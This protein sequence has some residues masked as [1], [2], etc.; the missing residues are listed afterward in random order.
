[1]TRFAYVE[2]G[3]FFNYLGEKYLRCVSIHD[4]DDD[5]INAI[6]VRDGAPCFF[7]NEDLV[8]VVEE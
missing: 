3:D 6:R 4:Q 8:E 2:H 5:Y 7:Y 1:M